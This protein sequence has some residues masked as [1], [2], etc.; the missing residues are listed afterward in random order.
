MIKTKWVDKQ[1]QAELVKWNEAWLLISPDPL[2]LVTEVYRGSLV[3][4]IPKRQR[5]SHI[6]L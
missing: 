2:K 4:R 6:K 1:H 5:E 3:F